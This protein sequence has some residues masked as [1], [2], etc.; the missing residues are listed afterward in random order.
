LLL[1]DISGLDV[2]AQLRDEESHE[3]VPVIVVTV[4]AERGAV[5]GFAVA[6]V[7]PKPLDPAALLAALSRAGVPPGR[8]SG[9]VLVLDDDPGSLKLMETT[10]HQLGLDAI[11]E[12]HGADA[13]QAVRDRPPRAVI[14]DL[15][16]PGM[17]GFEFLERLRSEPAGRRVP[18]IVWTIKD[19]SAAE[20]ATLRASADAVVAK[21]DGAAAAVIAELELFLAEAEATR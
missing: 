16:M 5:A 8:K 20:Q 2:L 17:N 11:C 6:D 7:L 10:L 14:L 4:V 1:P 13:L 21:G 15:M 3:G 9:P 18:V 12:S 19:L